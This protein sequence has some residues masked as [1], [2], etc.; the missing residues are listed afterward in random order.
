MRPRKHFFMP[1]D[2]ENH[3]AIYAIRN[4]FTAKEYIGSTMDLYTRL[5]NHRT[6]LANGIH[7]NNL[8]QADFNYFNN[9]F[10]EILILKSFNKVSKKELTKAEQEA[11]DG[12]NEN[13]LYNI[14]EKAKR[15]TRPIHQPVLI[16]NMNGKI[17]FKFKNFTQAIS[18]LGMMGK[19]PHYTGRIYSS[20][21]FKSRFYIETEEFFNNNSLA[22][23]KL[24]DKK[25][26]NSIIL[27]KDGK[28]YKEASPL[29]LAKKAKVNHQQL[30]D[31]IKLMRRKKQ[32][33]KYVKKANYT[34][35][36]I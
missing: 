17:K 24:V 25:S 31:E 20:K 34:I 32:E 7:S 6:Q 29:A 18:F 33:T 2:G 15:G 23:Q 36:L 12:Y 13:M 27:Q 11:I 19:T 9:N 21:K 22:I 10:F 26:Y 1:F 5:R 30:K 28:K 3:P 8:L 4:I 16:L 35:K 14:Q